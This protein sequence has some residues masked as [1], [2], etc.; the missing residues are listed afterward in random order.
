MVFELPA[1]FRAPERVVT[2]LAL[3]PKAAVFEKLG[4]LG[5]HMKLLFVKGYM[6]G[7]PL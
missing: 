3:G 5:Q 6:Q 2:K 1:E 4:K 7:K